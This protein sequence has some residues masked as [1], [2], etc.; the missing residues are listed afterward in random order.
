VLGRHFIF[1]ATLII[2]VVLLHTLNEYTMSYLKF[3][4][5]KKVRVLIK[6]TPPQNMDSYLIELKK[7]ILKKLE[8]ECSITKTPH[9]SVLR[10]PSFSGTFLVNRLVF[11]NLPVNLDG[12]FIKEGKTIKYIPNPHKQ[13]IDKLKQIIK[14]N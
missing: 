4:F 6:Y 2:V 9:M 11:T 12:Y 5:T 10:S 13:I 14:W 8:V 1:Q 7:R 3:L